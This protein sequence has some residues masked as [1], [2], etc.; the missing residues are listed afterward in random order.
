MRVGKKRIKKWCKMTPPPPI[1]IEGEGGARRYSAEF[2]R[3][4]E[5]REKVF[6]PK[7]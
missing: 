4:Q 6:S 1:A 3:L 7:N 2:Y 5:W